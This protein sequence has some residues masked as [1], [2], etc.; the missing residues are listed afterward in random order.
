MRMKASAVD[1][2]VGWLGPEGAIAGLE[3]SNLT[4]S[5]LLKLGEERGL[6][7]DKK[8]RRRLV[9]IEIV[10]SRLER[11]DKSQED[12]LR[13]S[14][15][16]LKNYLETRMVSGTELLRLLTRFG[17]EA[18]S[19]AKRNLLEFTAREISDLG[20]YQRVAKGKPAL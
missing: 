8:T 15:A 12:L 17:I 14:Q 3:A 18:R 1:T 19:E 20:M 9:A 7:I 16:E 6:T 2:L 5:D 11:I 4:V 10:N 13:M